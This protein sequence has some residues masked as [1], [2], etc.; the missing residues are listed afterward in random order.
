MKKVIINFFIPLI[1]SLILVFL[2]NTYFYYA[3]PSIIIIEFLFIFICIFTIIFASN[4]IADY[5]NY[6]EKDFGDKNIHYYYA[7]RNGIE[8]YKHSQNKY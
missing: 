5:I 8:A 6:N 4:Y 2:I 1:T 3:K 7:L